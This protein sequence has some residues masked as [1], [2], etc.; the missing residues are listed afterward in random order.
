MLSEVV[1]ILVGM[2][3]GV[4]EWLPVSSKTAVALA[5][6]ALGVELAEAYSLGLLLNSSAAVAAAYYFRGEVAEMLSALTRP[7]ASDYG[8]RLLRFTVIATLT[9]AVTGI[10]LYLTTKAFMRMFSENV[11]LLLIG[12]FLILTG[13]MVRGRERLYGEPL[14][15]VPPMTAAVIVGL[16]QGVAALPGISRSGVTVAALMALGCS[17]EDS[18]RYSFVLAIPATIFAALLDFAPSLLIGVRNYS[19]TLVDGLVAF[20]IAVA[21]SLLLIDALIKAATKTRVSIIALAL[22][23]LTIALSPFV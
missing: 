20:V 5:L 23:A 12:A 2:V 4:T 14:R 9:T 6:N 17:G 18:F 11:G 22:G 7:L 3:Q 21:V 10:P 19:I 13:L 15:A 16:A 8:A 1:W